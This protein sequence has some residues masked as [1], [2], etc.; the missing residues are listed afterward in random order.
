MIKFVGKLTIR[1]RNDYLENKIKTGELTRKQIE[2]EHILSMKPLPNSKLYFWQ[3]GYI[4]R[5]ITSFNIKFL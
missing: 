2:N 5:Q 3:I 1:L 4:T